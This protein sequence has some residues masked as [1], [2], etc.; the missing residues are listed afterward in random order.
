MEAVSR[1]AAEPAAQ[2][3]YLASLGLSADVDELALEFN[4]VAAA[5][6]DMRALS[7]LSADEH[8]AVAEIDRLLRHM[9]GEANAH[10]WTQGAL[11][12]SARWKEVRVRA[13]ECLLLLQQKR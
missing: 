4:D 1:L 5:R 9:S 6:D 11:V 7:E 2:R 3:A 12:T 13:Q 10:L 8:R